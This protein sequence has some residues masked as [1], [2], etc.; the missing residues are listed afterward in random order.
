SNIE[1]VLSLVPLK[2]YK[3]NMN[4]KYANEYINSYFK[5]IFNTISVKTN[6]YSGI[7]FENREHSTHIYTRV[8][9]SVVYL[10]NI[11]MEETFS[12]PLHVKK[13]SYIKLNIGYDFSRVNFDV[14]IMRNNKKVSTSNKIKGNMDNG[15]INIFEN[16]SLFLEEGEIW[17]FLFIFHLKFLSLL[18]IK[19][20]LQC[21]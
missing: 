14:K 1:L 17:V 13:G 7:I 4:T 21:Y 6:L 15:K 10:K 20:I 9:T 3:M 5:S 18:K 11:I 12:F 16:I 8:E 2:Y 19:I